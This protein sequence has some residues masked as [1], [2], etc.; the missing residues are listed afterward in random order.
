MADARRRALVAALVGILGASLGIAG[1]GHVY[2]REWRRAIAW[3]T[4]VVGA[5]LVLLSAFADPAAA[6]LSE[7]PTE[8]TVPI[9]GLLF[10]SAL[11]AYRIGMRGPGHRNDDGQPTCPACGGGLDRKLDFCPWCAEELEWHTEKP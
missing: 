11:D 6:T 2:L 1:A 7:L 8:V 9:I 3:F 4:F 10:L 5:G